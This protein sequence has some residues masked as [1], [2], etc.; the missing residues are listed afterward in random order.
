MIIAPIPTIEFPS[1]YM[2]T[3]RLRRLVYWFQGSPGRRSV[4]PEVP[5]IACLEDVIVSRDD[6]FARIDY[7]EGDIAATLLHIGPDIREMTDREIL[8]LHN[9][10]LGSQARRSI[11]SN[12]VF[13]VPA[14][15][16]QIEYFAR[17]DQ[18]V[19]RSRVLR[20][21]IQD[22][23]R[24]RVVVKVDDQELQLRQFGKLLT[25]YEG[26]GMRIE[27]VPEDDVHRRPVL[28]VREPRA[29]E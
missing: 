27:F 19:P 24:G 3:T 16:A 22:D 17:C 10:S 4:T 11:E 20:C 18:W 7:K 28:Q 23:D 14:G 29:Q 1:D 25:S 15:S 2:L 12:V 13:E 5:Y 8:D 9:E 6:D 21:L 26:W